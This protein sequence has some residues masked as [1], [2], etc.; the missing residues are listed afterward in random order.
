MFAYL[1]I[2]G[3]T[4]EVVAA[5]LGYSVGSASSPDAAAAATAAAAAATAAAAAATAGKEVNFKGKLNDKCQTRGYTVKYDANAGGPPHQRVFTATCML[6]DKTG[7]LLHTTTG[8]QAKTRKD[9][10]QSAARKMCELLQR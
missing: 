5:S 7:K 9:A 3:K 6:Y 8:E 10:E 1:K 4:K 2:T